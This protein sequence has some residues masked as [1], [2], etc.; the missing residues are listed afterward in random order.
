MAPT[1]FSPRGEP[2]S[3]RP[4]HRLA[5]LEGTKAIVEGLYGTARH[6]DHQKPGERGVAIWSGPISSFFILPDKWQ[7]TGHGDQGSARGTANNPESGDWK[8]KNIGALTGL[9]KIKSPDIGGDNLSC[10][11]ITD[12]LPVGL[13]CPCLGM[14]SP[15]V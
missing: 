15:T 11:S 9:H 4:S 12:F 6:P 14:P 8:G 5:H 13:L 7:V 1:A 2:T 3:N 10:A